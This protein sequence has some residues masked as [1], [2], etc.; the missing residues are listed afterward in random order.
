MPGFAFAEDGAEAEGLQKLQCSRA[1]K[2]HTV[3]NLS[4]QFERAKHLPRCHAD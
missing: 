1:K 4:R 3:L 2:C